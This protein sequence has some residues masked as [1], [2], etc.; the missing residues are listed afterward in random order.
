MKFKNLAFSL[1][2]GLLSASFTLGAQGPDMVEGDE[3][4][5]P[6]ETATVV[7]MSA[8][9][10]TPRIADLQV[11]LEPLR[12]RYLE[13]KRRNR[14]ASQTYTQEYSLSL[15]NI[16]GIYID[17]E[18]KALREGWP[19]K[20]GGMRYHNGVSV[21]L[22]KIYPNSF[23]EL[24][25]RPG[26][27]SDALLWRFVVF[28]IELERLCKRY[29]EN[30]KLHAILE[31]LTCE[32]RQRF[33][34]LLSINKRVREAE[35]LKGAEKQRLEK[36]TAKL[37]ET[38]CNV[39]KTKQ[40][41]KDVRKKCKSETDQIKK[42]E[43]AAQR[44]LAQTRRRLGDVLDETLSTQKRMDAIDDRIDRE[45][46]EAQENS[47]KEKQRE[48]EKRLRLLQE[49]VQ[50]AQKRNKKL[51]QKISQKQAREALMEEQ[52]RTRH[53]LMEA[54]ERTRQQLL[55]NLNKPLEVIEKQIT[56]VAKEVTLPPSE[57]LHQ[58]LLPPSVE[59]MNKEAEQSEPDQVEVMPRLPETPIE[60]SRL[61]PSV[62]LQRREAP[63]TVMDR[64]SLKEEYAFNE[65][66]ILLMYLE[67]RGL[68]PLELEVARQYLARELQTFA[69]KWKTQTL[70][71]EEALPYLPTYR[72]PLVSKKDDWLTKIIKK[73]KDYRELNMKP[74]CYWPS[75]LNDKFT[76]DRSQ[77]SLKATIEEIR[78]LKE[79]EQGKISSVVAA[80]GTVEERTKGVDEALTKAKAEL[81]HEQDLLRAEQAIVQVK[82]HKKKEK[83]ENRAREAGEKLRLKAEQDEAD[84]IRKTLEV[85]EELRRYQVPSQTLESSVHTN[86]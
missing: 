1:L 11:P 53:A 13:L 71:K 4:G 79:K 67:H 50:A 17:Q 16:V 8:P 46:R 37:K 40:N 73:T 62:D 5:R 69:Q 7:P 65:F 33:E 22:Y 3:L 54:Q 76:I 30:A 27:Q 25:K 23:L 10:R 86:N 83:L 81:A 43:E 48:G 31:N 14:E 34:E 57:Q 85:E 42:K 66:L 32:R 59:I 24:E 44:T 39:Q 52:E 49:Q 29:P 78:S 41:S 68:P 60:T 63:L 19:E 82:A 51:K 58:E 74:S 20:K 77:K 45:L 55:A 75:S 6:I 15:S 84:R 12:E 9:K 2:L 80:R 28:R 70:Q 38:Q 56:P 61:T 35:A 72:L 36:E 64:A 47:N 18:T 21:I 26:Y